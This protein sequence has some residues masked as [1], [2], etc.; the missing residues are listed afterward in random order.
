MQKKSL[1][2]PKADSLRDA[3]VDGLLQGLGAG[4]IMAAFLLVAG[5]FTPQSARAVL[6]ALARAAET[7]PAAIIAAHFAVAAVY[8]IVWGLLYHTVVAG[9]PL[10]VWMAGLLFGGALWLVGR[11]LLPASSVAPGSIFAGAHLVYGLALGLLTDRTP[12]Q[13]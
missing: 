9:R 13:P 8:G 3:V 4:A 7:S 6:F 5:L 10:P 12:A 2:G 1:S 11:L